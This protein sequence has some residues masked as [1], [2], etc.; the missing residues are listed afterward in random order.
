MSRNHH[1]QVFELSEEQC[2]QRLQGHQRKLGR[3]AFAEERDPDWPVA[4]PVNYAYVQGDI[5]IRTYEGSKLYAALRR[6]RVAF[7]VDEVDGEWS[8]GWSVVA[9]G[10]LQLVDDPEQRAAAAAQLRSWGADAAPHIV[11]VDVDILTGRE[12]VGSLPA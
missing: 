2:R 8:E 7:E 11:R 3:I 5:F 10:T 4:L 1:H 12:I 6:Q 9:V